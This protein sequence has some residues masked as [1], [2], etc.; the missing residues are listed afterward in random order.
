MVE[1]F[2]RIED[3]ALLRYIAEAEGNTEKALDNF[4]DDF[5]NLAKEL[6]PKD[7]ELLS[8]GLTW[9]AEDKLVRVFFDQPGRDDRL[10]GIY[11]ELGTSRN[12]AQPFAIPALEITAGN[13]VRYFEPEFSLRY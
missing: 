12:A 4:M 13:A 8:R 11:Q 6:A 9:E 10:Y 7:T 2:V 1:M 3:A 5:T